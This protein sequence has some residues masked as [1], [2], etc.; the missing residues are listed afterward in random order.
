[1]GIGLKRRFILNIALVLAVAIGSVGVLQFFLFRAEQWRLIDSRIESTASLLISSDLS[2]A[3]LKEFEEAENII[4]EV[5]G[6]ERFNQFVIIYNR[7]GEEVYRSRNS[8]ELP[9][10]IATN[11]KWQ[12]IEDEGHL[13]RVLTLPLTAESHPSERHRVLQTGLILDED[14]LRWKSISRHMIIYSVLIILL[15]ILTTVSLASA[16]LRPI[17]GLA[18]YLRHL[19]TRID[20]RS[21]VVGDIGHSF[22]SKIPSGSDEFGQLVNEVEN[23]RQRIAGGL[24]NTQA[25]TAQ[26]AHELKTPLTILQNSLERARAGEID[27]CG[28]VALNEASKEI[29][30]LNSLISGFLEWTA[31]E[32]FPGALE[33]LN[34]VRLGPMVRDLVEKIGRQHPDRLVLEGSSELTVFAQRGFLQQAISNVIV[35]ALRYSPSASQVRITLDKLCLQVIDEGPGLPAEVRASLGQ[36]FNYGPSANRGFGLGLAWVNTICHKYGWKLSFNRIR[37]RN[38]ERDVTSVRIDFPEEPSDELS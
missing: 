7:K 6:G 29:D 37:D 30:H 15:I 14:L 31:A 33:E 22:T 36:P 21:L 38:S 9:A 18:Q 13:I 16:L 2:N 20:Q 12:T 26:M 17:S 5:V 32:N 1:L 19:G 8:D 4:L 28:L 3:E 11:Q 34:A 23:L 35:N 25:W 10:V 24:R 27:P